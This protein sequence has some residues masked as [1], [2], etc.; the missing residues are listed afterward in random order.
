VAALELARLDVRCT[1]L[2]DLVLEDVL[3][4]E[5]VDLCSSAGGEGK[6]PDAIVAVA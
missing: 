5:R 1:G 3:F 4:R 6:L 2:T